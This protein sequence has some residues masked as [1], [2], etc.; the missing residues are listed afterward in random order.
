M[1]YELLERMDKA[2]DKLEGG[3]EGVQNEA[4]IKQ[5]SETVHAVVLKF[6][7]RHFVT[8]QMLSDFSKSVKLLEGVAKRI[9]EA[10]GGRR[11]RWTRVR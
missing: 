5:A 1:L 3:V 7:K 11:M 10:E 8:K 2:A 9:S 4:E 6:R